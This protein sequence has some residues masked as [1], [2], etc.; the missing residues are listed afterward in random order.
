MKNQPYRCM[1]SRL[2]KVKRGRPVGLTCCILLCFALPAWNSGRNMAQ[3]SAPSG[4]PKVA[5]GL[6]I[7]SPVLR[8]EFD[9]NL[10]SRVVALFSGSL[11]ILTPFSA[12]ETVT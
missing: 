2:E 4:A 10:R 5:P 9:H 6:Q 12:S 8:I 11:K 7:Q 1:R 3:E